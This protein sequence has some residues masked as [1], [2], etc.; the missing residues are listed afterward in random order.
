[1]LKKILVSDV[2]LGMHL[3]AMEGS[4][5]DHPFWKTKFVLN[6]ADLARLR[7]S[8]V[9]EVWID[10]SKGVDVDPAPAA[11]MPVMSAAAA[12][13]ADAAHAPGQAPEGVASADAA[14][15]DASAAPAAPRRAPP[16]RRFEDELSH[17]SALCHQARAQVVSMFDE[18]RLGK[19]IDPECCLPV[20][21]EIT[22]SIARNP[23]ALVSLVRLKTQDDYSYMHSVA[24]CALMVSLGR[25]M[26]M[27]E[28]E[29]RVAGLAGMLHDLGKALM[30]VEVLNKPGKLTDEEFSIMK[31]HPE[32][33]HEL[34]VV[35]GGA[36]AGA[37]D[38]CLHHHERMDG[39]GYPH[40]LPGD[41]ISLLARMGA[42]CDV[43]DAVTSNRPYK[44][45]WDPADSIA[46]MA[47]W[48]GHFDPALLATFVR[49][50]G[51]YPTGS[52][53]RLQSD[54]LAVVMEQNPHALT[55]PVVR[56]FYSLKSRMP[57]TLARVDLSASGC[58]D[59][60]VAREA[61]EKW[62][63]SFLDEL[64]GGDVAARR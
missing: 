24:V 50:V 27:T 28:D 51:I 10:A 30:P 61:P 63:F 44:S 31:A 37:M 1:M 42:I 56:V 48:K 62:N 32:R 23:G 36:H 52:L 5:I 7:A 54:K 22:E 20:V 45:G 35:G 14:A 47:S 26:G 46:K 49:S 39:T 21:T 60:I 29:C 15:T 40:G 4:W 25:E 3:H 58:H 18:A 11:P 34:L 41:Q 53:V 59:R 55:S 43:Y 19:A 38:V 8:A 6:E 64:W 16:L 33:G 13:P 57:V 17:A 12:P 9:R 2:R